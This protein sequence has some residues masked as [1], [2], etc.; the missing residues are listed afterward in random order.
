M[1]PMATL[2]SND[3]LNSR[4]GATP[5]NIFRPVDLSPDASGYL[6]IIRSLAA[7]TVMF[8][9][10]RA[11]Y[12]VDYQHVAPSVN[13]LPVR[14]LY[15]LTGFGH[16]AVMVF[17]VLSGLFIS[18]SVLRSLNQSTWRWRNYIV[19]RGVRL[20]LVLVPGLLLGALW[21]LVGVHFFNHSGIY[22]A[23][24]AAFGDGIP[25][26][27]LNLSSFFGC[28]FFLQTR[29]TTV[30]GSNGPLWSL[31]NE[32]WYYV[33]FPVL[34]ALILSAKSRSFTVVLYFG[35]AI[36]AVWVLG[37]ALPG[38]VVWLA[39][40]CVALTSRY[41]RFAVSRNWPVI[42]YTLGAAALAATCLFVARAQ[43]G[44]LG[45]D[46]AVG[47]SVALLT[48][49]IVQ[50]RVPLGLIGRRLAK[51]FAGF[52]YS[53]Y[54]LHFPVLLL[55]RAKWLPTFRWQPD[56]LHLL[57]GACIASAVLVYAFA[58]AQVTEQK[59]SVVRMWVRRQFAAAPANMA[60]NPTSL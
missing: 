10:C 57:L 21:D 56:A 9:H 53:L 32:F 42:L 47:L 6:D 50:L 18:S 59:T 41:F 37:G 22:S 19:D 11:F 17:F 54:V 48:H 52:S 23:P 28:L 15:F 33:L 20:Y 34:I 30:L 24:L 44:S 40:A 1:I 38:F 46:L 7:I 12:F 55:I 36:F 45:S 29:F 8:G 13:S 2:T 31:F 49:G 27:R 51:T 35:I 60:Q 25:A 14:A 3:Q 4:V 5:R 39:G 26:Q 43:R 16:Q 58:I